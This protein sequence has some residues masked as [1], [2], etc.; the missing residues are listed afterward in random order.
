MKNKKRLHKICDDMGIKPVPLN[1]MNDTRYRHV[2]KCTNSLETMMP[3]ILE[4]LKEVRIRT[5]RQ[6][7]IAGIV[8]GKGLG[9]F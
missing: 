8:V 1:R 4:Y 3:P 7:S 9:L 5:D 2:L 6:K